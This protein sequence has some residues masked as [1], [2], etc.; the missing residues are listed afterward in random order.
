[1]DDD[2]C[3]AILAALVDLSAD[4][5]QAASSATSEHVQRGLH[6]ADQLLHARARAYAGGLAP[7]EDAEPWMCAQCGQPNPAT[8]G[9]CSKCDVVIGPIGPSIHIPIRLTGYEDELA[10]ARERRE[11]AGL[12][13]ITTDVTDSGLEMS[14]DLGEDPKRKK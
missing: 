3:R 4:I 1:M 5:K 11:L 14:F 13:T 8:S 2:T 6:M 7:I 9:Q 10:V 12:P